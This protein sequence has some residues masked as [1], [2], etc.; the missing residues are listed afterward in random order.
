MQMLCRVFRTGQYFQK[1]NNSDK[2]QISTSIDAYQ[3]N[4]PF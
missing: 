4:T 2:Q 1:Y 3:K